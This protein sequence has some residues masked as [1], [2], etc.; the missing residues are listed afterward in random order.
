MYNTGGNV[1]V[2][3]TMFTV[4]PTRSNYNRP[5]VTPLP[6]GTVYQIR[7]TDEMNK[8]VRFNTANNSVYMPQQQQQPYA[9][10]QFQ[11]QP[12]AQMPVIQN[13]KMAYTV[14]AAAVQQP[15]YYVASNQVYQGGYVSTAPQVTYAQ[16]SYYPAAVNQTG[17]YSSYPFSYSYY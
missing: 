14:P 3:Q 16:P 5:D 9:Y 1:G 11:P 15:Y 8:Q 7:R 13:Q 6:K 12:Q 10:Q 17:Y 4:D 2:G